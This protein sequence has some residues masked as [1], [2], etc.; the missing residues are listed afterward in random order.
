MFDWNALLDRVAATQKGAKLRPQTVCRMLGDL[1]PADAV[2]SLDCGA[3]THFAARM[4]R[5]RDGQR[6]SGSGT[7]VSMASG[8]PYAIA[9]SFAF[10]DRPSIAIVGDGGFAM[11]MA[12]L[13]TAVFHR[14]NVKVIVLNND[15]LAEVRFEQREIGNPEYG[16]A[17]G[18]I[19]FARF[20]EACGARGFRAASLRELQP[21]MQGWLAAPGVAVLDVQVDADEEATEPDAVKA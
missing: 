10:P 2:Y 11:L 16:C 19:D 14:R 9:A 17:L 15:S 4:I 8:V 21:A 18:H 1:A 12:E 13:S 6:W 5:I 3:N 20:A 7:L